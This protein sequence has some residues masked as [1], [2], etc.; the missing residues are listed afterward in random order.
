MAQKEMKKNSNKQVVIVVSVIVVALLVIDLT[1]TG[2][3]K[4]GYNVVRCGGVPVAVD[5]GGFA[6]ASKSYEL[7]GNY[8]PGGVNTVYYCTEKEV[9][10]LGVLKGLNSRFQ[11]FQQNKH[12]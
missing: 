3:L 10:D 11:E 5:P 9:I 7:P 8:I 1:F 2:F 12:Q 6:A 4:F